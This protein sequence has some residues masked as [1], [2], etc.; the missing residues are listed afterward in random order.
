MSIKPFKMRGSPFQR[1]FG[2]RRP[3][4]DRGGSLFKF[5]EDDL[6]KKSGF[7]PIEIQEDDQSKRAARAKYEMGVYKVDPTKSKI[8]NITDIEDPK[9]RK[10]LY[11]VTEKERK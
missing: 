4:L 11:K 9:Q 2:T 6:K 8:P 5:T 1:N 10:Q 7:G 3:V